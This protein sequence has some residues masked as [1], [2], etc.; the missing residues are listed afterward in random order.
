MMSK[1]FLTLKDLPGLPAFS[2]IIGINSNYTRGKH[3]SVVTPNGTYLEDYPDFFGEI[4][5]EVNGFK[6]GDICTDVTKKYRYKVILGTMFQGEPA[7]HLEHIDS[8]TKFLCRPSTVTK[9]CDYP[10]RLPIFSEWEEVFKDC[11]QSQLKVLAAAQLHMLAYQMNKEWSPTQDDGGFY[12]IKHKDG[13]KVRPNS[14]NQA[15]YNRVVFKTAEM[16]QHIIDKF[17]NL[18]KIVE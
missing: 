17:S 1:Q 16:A 4:L 2:T 14:S 15:Q 8:F 5:E 18:L 12:I 3:F 9:V 11:K 13:P 7:L 6:K 10:T